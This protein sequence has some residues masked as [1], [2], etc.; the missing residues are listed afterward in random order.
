MRMF[1]AGNNRFCS[2]HGDSRVQSSTPHIEAVI[3]SWASVNAAL[4][5]L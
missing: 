3:G 1:S 2:R 4:L 5:F